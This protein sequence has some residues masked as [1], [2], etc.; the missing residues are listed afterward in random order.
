MAA[1]EH[2]D[3]KCAGRSVDLDKCQSRVTGTRLGSLRLWDRNPEQQ[4][5]NSESGRLTA[6]IADGPM[7]R[8]CPCRLIP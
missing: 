5:E 7:D 4:R 8:E 2:C 1:A 3:L 6:T